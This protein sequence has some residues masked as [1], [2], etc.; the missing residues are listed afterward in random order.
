MTLIA[1]QA[2]LCYAD[3]TQEDA[4]MDKKL[5]TST[6]LRRLHQ[7]SDIHVF[8]KTNQ[9]AM[10]SLTLSELLNSLARERNEIPE[11]IILRAGIERT[12]GHQLFNGTR[13]PSR[14]KTLQLA[15][16][17]QLNE[18]DTQRLLQVA[19]KSPLYPRI[20]RDA[21]ILFALNKK[22]TLMDTQGL[23]AELGLA[24][25]GGIAKDE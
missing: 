1:R 10:T 22:L 21:V 17:F 8:L 6:L 15:F 14:D 12:F 16:G 7:T 20:Q 13:R 19:V 24:M 9:D 2:I 25:L 11:H 23:L 5:R 4:L 18:S 3:F